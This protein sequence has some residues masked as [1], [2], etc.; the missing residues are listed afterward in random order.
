MASRNVRMKVNL[1]RNP[2]TEKEDFQG[3]SNGI[4]KKVGGE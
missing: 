2:E 3:T 1:G 4:Y